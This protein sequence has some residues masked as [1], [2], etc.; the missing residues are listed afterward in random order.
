MEL[1]RRT[2]YLGPRFDELE[3]ALQDQFHQY[4]VERG[5]DEEF[6]NFVAEYAEWKEQGQYMNWLS[7]VKQFVDSNNKTKK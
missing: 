5:F 6:G 2:A 7:Q 1:E 3:D 4:L